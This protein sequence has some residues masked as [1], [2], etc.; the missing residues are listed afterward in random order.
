MTNAIPYTGV[1]NL[2]V[3]AA[4]VK[5]RRFLNDTIAEHIGPPSPQRPG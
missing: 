5:Y 3:M 2:E 4:A 1:D